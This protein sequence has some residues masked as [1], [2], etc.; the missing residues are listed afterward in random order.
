MARR[1]YWKGYLR[2]SL[3]S[4]P[5]QLFPATLERAK[6]RLHQV[7]KKT[8]H[9]IKSLLVDAE[10]GRQVDAG[11]VVIGYEYSRGR[12]VE[13]GQDELEAVAIEDTH[14][15]EIDE[16][17]PRKESTTLSEPALL[18]DPRTRRLAGS[19]LCRDP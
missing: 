13:L 7:N 11:D 14:V 6:I 3:V 1:A 19:G 10:T 18:P 17:V 5:I 9:R 8:G 16:F 4:C 2:L 12:Y 15:V